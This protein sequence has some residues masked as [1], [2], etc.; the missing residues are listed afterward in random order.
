MY[1][2][3][4]Q[5]NRATALELLGLQPVNGS[6][7]APPS[8][9]AAA[10]AGSGNLTSSALL[11]SPQLQ[12]VPPVQNLLA[13]TL[14]PPANNAV[15]AA[16]L[17]QDNLRQEASQL[18][19]ARASYQSPLDAI[20]TRA[21]IQQTP[22]QDMLN[23]AF[24]RGK[25][26]VILSLLRNGTIDPLLLKK[27]IDPVQQSRSTNRPS[28]SDPPAF[29]KMPPVSGSVSAATKGSNPSA[30]EALGTNGL[31]RRKKNT[32]YF[33]ASSL[34]DPDAATLA[35]RRTRGGVTEPFPEK[36]HR[37][38]RDAEENGE[39]DV[40]SFFPHGR[41]FAIHHEER[42]CREIM[43]RYFKQSRFSSFQRQLNLY[44]FTRITSGPDARGYYHELF[45]KGRPALVIHMR[46]VGFPKPSVNSMN[47][48]KQSN[49]P[50][51]PDFY[52]M[53]PIK[54]GDEE[55]GKEVVSSS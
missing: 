8:V 46:R 18:M 17:G 26:E 45:L 52:A 50:I 2:S 33:D 53:A 4:Q 10:L 42:F 12:Q 39:S 24:Q 15:L 40:I 43:P 47:S 35:N 19:A 36:L 29:H 30:L 3:R 23:E 22:K 48:V 55:T 28:T 25:D 31:E 44:G 51:S 16:L 1:P 5:N 34:A 11:G 14:P 37:L 38:L 6:I 13:N 7:A 41:A 20:L 27:H 54:G 49:P 21:P 9:L 32:P